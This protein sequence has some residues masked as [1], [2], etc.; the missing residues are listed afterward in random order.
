MN[1][2]LPEPVVRKK[3][4]HPIWVGCCVLG[5]LGLSKL[6][7]APRTSANYTIS[8]D[9]LDAGGGLAASLSY[10]ENASLGT[11]VGVASAGA[12]VHLLKAGFLARL[13]D[14][15]G[16]Q[17][18]SATGGLAAN[19]DVPEGGTL[20]LAAVQELDDATFHPLAATSVTWSVAS[21]P[22]NS[23][24]PT[25]LAAAGLVYEDAAA[26]VSGS[27]GGFTATLPITVQN[28]NPDDFGSYAADGLPDGWQVQYFGAGNPQAAPGAD[29]SGT[30]Q[31]NLFKYTAGLDPTDPASRFTLE[32]EPGTGEAAEKKLVFTPVFLDRTYVVEYSTD[33][34]GG[35]WL[36]LAGGQASTL[37]VVRTVT[38]SAAPG[39][40][41]FYRVRIS[42][43]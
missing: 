34:A 2:P 15:T 1:P 30:G 17:L 38:D 24:S 26:A 32:I 29:A 14:A 8:A 31:T 42:K 16:V 13:T 27:F 23:V 22:L 10:K 43:P 11:T 18:V 6:H 36:P 35:V 12:P 4:R 7:A 41:K 37:G 39:P 19:Y 3:R 40:A 21:G 9:T 20:L 28:V 5:L 33:L 25:G